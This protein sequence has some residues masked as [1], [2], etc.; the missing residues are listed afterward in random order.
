MRSR[1]AAAAA[2]AV[3]D[4]SF[5]ISTIQSRRLS[6]LF[7]ARLRKLCVVRTV[8][9]GAF[10]CWRSANLFRTEQASLEE[11]VSPSQV[12]LTGDGSWVLCA[13]VPA[14]IRGYTCGLWMLF[15][16]LT[17]RAYQLDEAV[18]QHMQQTKSCNDVYMLS[19]SG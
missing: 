2:A 19:L 9:S 4:S 16:T 7:D 12:P 18:R 10:F 8:C 1:C 17:A 3:A 13:D 11:V 15:H 5:T 14:H 6:K